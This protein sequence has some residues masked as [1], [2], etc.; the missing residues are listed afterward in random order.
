MITTSRRRR[1]AIVTA[2]LALTATVAVVNGPSA[3]AAD[4]PFSIDGTVPDANTTELPDPFGSVK[5]L[6]PKN[7]STTKIV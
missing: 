1:A 2:A 6:G 7:A 5:E 3:H 4:G